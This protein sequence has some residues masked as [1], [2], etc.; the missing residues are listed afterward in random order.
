MPATP[1]EPILTSVSSFSIDHD[2]IITVATNPGA[3]LTESSVEEG[4]RAGAALIAGGAPAPLVW[5]AREIG[6]VEPGARARMV[7]DW[8]RL[9]KAAA[10]VGGRPLSRR[11]VDVFISLSR[12]SIPVAVFEDLDEAKDWART[13]LSA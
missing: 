5:D 9:L 7:A 12:T 2:G 6:G 1:G 3:V 4:V 13:F 11:I 10:I 8:P